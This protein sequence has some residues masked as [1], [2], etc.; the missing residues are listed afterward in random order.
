MRLNYDTDENNA[1][2]IVIFSVSQYIIYTQRD[3]KFKDLFLYLKEKTLGEDA[4]T[5]QFVIKRAFLV[6]KI[7]R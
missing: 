6:L 4:P 1:T 7:I 3:G 5:Q 2:N